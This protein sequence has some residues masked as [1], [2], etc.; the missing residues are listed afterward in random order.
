MQHKLAELIDVA[1]TQEIL[2]GFL[3]AVGIPAA[4]ADLEGK[5]VVVTRSQRICADFH[6]LNPATCKRCIESDT[7]LANELMQGKGF[8]LYRCLNGLTDAASPIV[9]EGEHIANAFIG[10]FL[11]EKPD[12]DFFSRQADEHGFDKSDYFHALSEVPIVDQNVLPRLLAFLTSFAEMI[13]NQGLKQLRQLEIEKELEAARDKLQFQNEELT[14]SEEEL[15]AQNEELLLFREQIETLARFPGENP[16][17]V[18]RVAAGGGL[19]Y[20][21]EAARRF[22]V[23]PQD[24]REGGDVPQF[25]RQ[26][27]AEAFAK[28]ASN[29]LDAR[30]GDKVFSCTVVP[31]LDNGYVNI[32]ATDITE[33]KRMEDELL[34]A[35]QEWERT[36]DTVPDLIAILDTEHRIV[37]A[38]R[39]MARRIGLEPELCVGLRCHE[40]VHNS[41]A[42]LEICPHQ[43]SLLDGR[44]HIA[45]VHEER[46]GGH[47]LVSTTPLR[48]EHGAVVGT[49]HV[50]RDITGRKKMEEE[51]RKSRDE[52][53]VRVQQR[54]ADLA[55]AVARLELINQ[56]LQEFAFVASHDLQEP[57][58]KIQSFSE[59]VVRSNRDRVDEKGKD[60]LARMQQAAERM[61]QLLKDLLNYSRIATQPEPFQ[62]VDMKEVVT[63]A[64]EVFEYKIRKDGGKIEIS[65]MPVIEADSGQMTRLFQN[66]ISNAV[67]YASPQKILIRIY[68]D[69]DHSFCRIYVEDNGIGFEE[70]YLDRIFSPFQRL[71]GRSEFSGTGMGL[72]ICRKIVERHSGSITAK[73]SPGK[74]STFIVALPLR[75]K[76]EAVKGQQAAFKEKTPS[77]E[78]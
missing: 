14:A 73:S 17:P 21:N 16:S 9:I 59:M 72:A 27:V 52:L 4:I 18:L 5:A 47:F 60:Y 41:P 19:L 15:R 77:P 65:E 28:G 23:C 67:K 8:S 71:H 39:E 38:N 62:P 70:K 31:V 1:K 46:L 22:M 24:W 56:E 75:Q 6:R 49:V 43:R 64:A 32:Y 45:E 13:A 7:I 63:E 20:S 61:Q 69:R 25:W 76:Q 42:P 36:F 34:R 44:E 12:L 40:C 37:R 48:D 35:K 66:L 58:R 2:A 55:K 30:I 53:E 54:T 68:S 11:T 10:Q 50:A 33:R 51:L 57:L 74:G 3:G 29:T 26:V 78:S